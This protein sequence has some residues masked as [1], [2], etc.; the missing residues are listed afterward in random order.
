ML[1]TLIQELRNAEEQGADFGGFRERRRMRAGESGWQTMV[2]C[3][4]FGNI[5]TCTPTIGVANKIFRSSI[6]FFSVCTFLAF[7]PGLRLDGHLLLKEASSTSALQKRR[8]QSPPP[9]PPPLQVHDSPRAQ[10]SAAVCSVRGSVHHSRSHAADLLPSLTAVGVT[11]TANCLTTR[12]RG[13]PPS[14]RFDVASD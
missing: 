10:H 9:A 7:E 6:F 1:A 4:L 14:R 8:P 3:R 13:R 2:F 11:S 12:R 5:N